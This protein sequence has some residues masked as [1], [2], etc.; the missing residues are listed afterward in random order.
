V[1]TVLTPAQS[2]FIEEMGRFLGGYG[3]TPMAGRM[4]GWLLLCEPPEQTAADIAEALQASRG[5]IS[6]T[7]R[8]LTSAGFIRRTTRR[9]DRREYFSSPPE[10]LD[11]MLSNASVVYRRLREIAEH[12]LAAA[13]DSA[14]AEARLREFYEV[15]SFIELELPR[16]IER[17]LRDR[18]AIDAEAPVGAQGNEQANPA[19]AGGRD[20]P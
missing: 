9:G 1:T 7:A 12:G 10:A 8:I 16:L 17:F 5:A 6:G 13:G 14:S 15:V 20:S 18:A 19:E 11:S 4:W 3:M 2:A